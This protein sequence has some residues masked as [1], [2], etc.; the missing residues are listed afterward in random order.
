VSGV[1]GARQE[2]LA[3]VREGW[4]LHYRFEG[5]DRDLALLDGDRRYA[6]GL[7][8][9]AVAGD[10]EGVSALAELITRCARAAA[11]GRPADAESAWH[12][13]AEALR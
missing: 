7:A 4:E 12:E 10:L 9:L 2:A 3:A 8:A 13:A 6:D 1:D 11:E 5:E